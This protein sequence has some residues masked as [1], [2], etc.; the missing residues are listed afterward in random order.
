MR[1]PLG[2]ASARQVRFSRSGGFPLAQAVKASQRANFAGSRGHLNQKP[3]VASPLPCRLPW[4]P[5]GGVALPGG[6]L[7]MFG[8]LAGIGFAVL[9]RLV[10]FEQEPCGGVFDA[11]A[12][13]QG[14]L[15]PH[16]IGARALGVAARA[17]RRVFEAAGVTW[18]FA[19]ARRGGGSRS[20]GGGMGWAFSGATTPRASS[21]AGATIRPGWAATIR[22]VGKS[23]A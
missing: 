15:A 19:G 23:G 16:E 11:V 12:P 7:G 10:A 8:G 4:L 17:D 5:S 18:P 2:L 9:L 22:T 20:H 3:P 13:R 6:E 14:D 1:Q 21:V